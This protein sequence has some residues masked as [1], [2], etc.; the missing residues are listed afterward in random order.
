M[1]YNVVVSEHAN[2]QLDNILFYIVCKLGNRQAAKAVY[3]DVLKAYDDL[4]YMAGSIA[5][6]NDPY[7]AAKGYHKLI[8]DHHNYILLFQILDNTVYVNGIFHMLENYSS[9]L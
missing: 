1:T 8:L 9:K 2:E 7:L 6:C 5:L 4:E 3:N